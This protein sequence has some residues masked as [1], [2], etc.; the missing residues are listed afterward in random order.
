M[1]DIRSHLLQ[2][3]R[4]LPVAGTREPRCRVPRPAASRDSRERS[5]GCGWF[6]SSFELSSGLLVQEHATP[7]AL[8]PE[9]VLAR[10]L[11]RE[12]APRGD[13]AAA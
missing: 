5:L 9:W 8:G 2:R 7:D 12:L 6:D 11:E 3:L 13:A 10:W 4:R 1:D